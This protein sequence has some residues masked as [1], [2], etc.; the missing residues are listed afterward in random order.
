M[1]KYGYDWDSELELGIQVKFNNWISE[2]QN[3]D[4]VKIPRHI[5]I[6]KDD[7]N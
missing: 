2:L 7:K 4:K 3:L 5:G 6:T 1:W